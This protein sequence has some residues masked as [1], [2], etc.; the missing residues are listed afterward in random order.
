M[1]IQK[2]NN[3]SS[4]IFPKGKC[5]G[6]Q[7]TPRLDRFNAYS[8]WVAP[9]PKAPKWL[10]YKALILADRRDNLRAAVFLWNIPLE[11]PL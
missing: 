10:N 1:N 2:S 11:M 4:E 9:L 7:R 8:L 6:D 3:S 5:L